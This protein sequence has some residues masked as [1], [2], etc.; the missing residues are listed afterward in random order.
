MF[1]PPLHHGKQEAF[2]LL[3]IVKGLK[4]SNFFPSRHGISLLKGGISLMAD[5]L[6]AAALDFLQLEWK[7]S[8]SRSAAMSETLQSRL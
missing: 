1:S 2:P 5:L 7:S 3:P 8:L 6:L 4:R